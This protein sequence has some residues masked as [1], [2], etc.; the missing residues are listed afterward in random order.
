MEMVTGPVVGR[1]FA[2]RRMRAPVEGGFATVPVGIGN[3]TLIWPE[4]EVKV[5]VPLFASVRVMMEAEDNVRGIEIDVP[6]DGALRSDSG[7]NAVEGDGP[8][9]G[10]GDGAKG[11]TRGIL[12]GSGDDCDVSGC[13]AVLVGVGP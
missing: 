12:D 4:P 1:L 9:G 8:P 5:V 13:G 10:D 11:I 6:I 7:G 2:K 3:R